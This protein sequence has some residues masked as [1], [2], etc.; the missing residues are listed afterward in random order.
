MGLSASKPKKAAKKLKIGLIV[1]LYT[2][3][4]GNLVIKACELTRNAQLVY[5]EIYTI[6]FKEFLYSSKIAF[7]TT[8]CSYLDIIISLACNLS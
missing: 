6:S 5:S 7:Q 3:T 2:R 8:F 4:I 1:D